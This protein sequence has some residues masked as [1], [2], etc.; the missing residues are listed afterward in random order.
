M[1]ILYLFLLLQQCA[2]NICF[3]LHCGI[4]VL[5][6][7]RIQSNFNIVHPSPCHHAIN[8]CFSGSVSSF[9][10]ELSNLGMLDFAVARFIMFIQKMKVFWGFLA[11]SLSLEFNLHG[12]YPRFFPN[13][14]FVL[15]FEFFRNDGLDTTPSFPR[16]PTS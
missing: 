5:S 11:F 4:L 14:F 10:W 8:Q 1:V 15:G 13:D 6:F 7:I 2:T 9:I 16:I 3:R 12:L